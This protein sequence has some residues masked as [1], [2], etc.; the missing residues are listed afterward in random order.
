[1]KISSVL[2]PVF[3]PAVRIG[4]GVYAGLCVVLFFR[5][6]GMVYH[7]SRKLMFDPS[8]VNLE[9]EDVSFACDGEQI[10]A[11]HVPAEDARGTLLMCHGNGGNIGDRIYQLEFFH[12]LGLNVLIF[13][14]RGYGASAGTPSEEGTYRDAL[15]AWNWL[16]EKRNVPE[17]SIVVQGRSLGGAVAAWLASRVKPA[18]LILDSTFT[19]IPD[20]GSRMYPYLPVRLLC[21]YDYNTLRSVREVGCPVLVAHSRDDEMVPFRH[22]QA[23][24]EAAP[25]P[26]F[27]V[28]LSGSHNDGESFFAADYKAELD[29]FFAL[30]LRRDRV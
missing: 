25:E 11:W 19:S 1:M 29:K 27:F 22:G 16:I 5:Q 23:I 17:G 24:F 8:N 6:S 4:V 21:R 13:D 20:M 2:K 7:P 30:V 9:Y 26:K 15:A 3:W 12:D 28:A 14:Y 10:A 18:G